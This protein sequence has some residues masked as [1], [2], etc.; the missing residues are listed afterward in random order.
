[1]NKRLT[2]DVEVFQEIIRE[3]FSSG[4]IGLLERK[5]SENELH[6]MYALVFK[7]KMYISAFRC[8]V[9]LCVLSSQ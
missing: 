5:K 7:C 1:M 6:A 4:M 2:R 3:C 9:G 8:E